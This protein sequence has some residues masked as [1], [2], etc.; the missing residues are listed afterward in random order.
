MRV[1]TPDSP[2]KICLNPPTGPAEVLFGNNNQKTDSA[3]SFGGL[4]TP[5]DRKKN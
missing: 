3:L 1:M 5:L 2:V 4:A